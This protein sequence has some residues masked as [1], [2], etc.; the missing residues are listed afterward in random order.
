[1]LKFDVMNESILFAVFLTATLMI[2]ETRMMAVLQ[3]YPTVALVEN[4]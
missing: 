1:M 2:M 4:Y 3:Y